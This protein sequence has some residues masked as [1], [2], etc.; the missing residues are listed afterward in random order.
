M[1]NTQD[2]MKR[3]IMS[4]ISANELIKDPSHVSVEIKTSG[5]LM[6]KKNEIHLLGRV[7]LDSEK[8]EIEKIIEA[9]AHGMTVVNTL[10][11]KKE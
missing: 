4:R 9:E 11:V 6:W 5:A 1:G 7:G 10:R 2:K 3:T 8:S